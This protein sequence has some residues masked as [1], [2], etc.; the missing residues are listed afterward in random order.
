M[1]RKISEL[2]MQEYNLNLGLLPLGKTLK[3]YTWGYCLKVSACRHCVAAEGK[4]TLQS[5]LLAV[6]MF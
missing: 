6:R 5:P 3:S 2:D 4:N 1:S